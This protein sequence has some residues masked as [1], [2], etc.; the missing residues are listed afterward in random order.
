[1]IDYC[2]QNLRVAWGRV[3]FPWRFWQ[4]E[5][6]DDP[7]T[8]AKNGKLNPRVQQAMDMAARLNK[9]GIPIILSGWFPPQWAV[10]GNLNFRPTP[11]RRL[12]QSIG[13]GQYE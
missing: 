6:N 8:L 3:E 2:L 10:V 7:V 9:M 1:M 5:K 12:G 11:G 13:Y 4:P